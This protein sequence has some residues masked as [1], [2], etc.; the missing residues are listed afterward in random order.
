MLYK[1]LM[2]A[3]DIGMLCTQNKIFLYVC[4]TI[5]AHSS[6]SKFNLVF[7]PLPF[8]PFIR[9][10]PSNYHSVVHVHESFF[11]FAQSFHP[12]MTP[13]LAVCLFSLCESVPIFLVSS[14]CSLDSTYECNHM[15]FVFLWLFYFTPAP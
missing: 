3:Q 1:K 4:P 8:I 12:L 6:F 7:F 11:L 13:P 2:K 10:S 14:V 9:P 15:L 5:L